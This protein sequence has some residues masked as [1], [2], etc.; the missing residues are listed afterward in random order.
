MVQVLRQR[1]VAHLGRAA[2]FNR[3]GRVGGLEEEKGRFAAGEAHLLG[4]ILIV[5]AHAVNAVDRKTLATAHNGEAGN[6]RG[7]EHVAHE[8][9]GKNMR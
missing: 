8:V 9:L 7:S 3:Q 4:M 1:G 6:S 2:G 5:A